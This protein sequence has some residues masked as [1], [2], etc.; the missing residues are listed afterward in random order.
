MNKNI[1]FGLAMG[2]VFVFSFFAIHVN[3][4]YSQENSVESAVS[5][6]TDTASNMTDTAS[7]MTDTASNMTISGQVSGKGGR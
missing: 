4:A 1:I 5:N 2:A 7:N 6:M 3:P